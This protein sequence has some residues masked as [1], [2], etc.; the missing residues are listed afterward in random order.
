MS[1]QSLGHLPRAPL[2]YSLAMVEYAKVPEMRDYANVIMESLRHIYPDINEYTISTLNVNI[3]S[4][5]GL[6][7]SERVDI[8]QWRMTDLDGH[9]GVIF[10]QD[11]V[12]FHT[13]KYQHFKDFS[14]KFSFVCSTLFEAANIQYYQKI[15]IRHIDNILPIDDFSLADLV[16]SEYVCPN[17]DKS[18]RPIF[19]RVEHIYLTPIGQLNIKAFQLTNQPKVPNDLFPIAEQLSNKNGLL[20]LVE[21]SFILAD[22]DHIFIADKLLDADINDIVS[23]LNQLHEQCSMGFRSMVTREAFDAWNQE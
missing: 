11:R 9:F 16:K 4:V 19:S 2:V 1:Y 13:T 21:K 8:Q 3:D 6:G 12:I 20:D 23:K 22:T 10:G 18:L 17:N 14:N 5:S 15:G 7:K